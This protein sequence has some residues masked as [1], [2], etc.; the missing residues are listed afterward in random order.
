MLIYY[1]WIMAANLRSKTAEEKEDPDDG[2]ERL[3]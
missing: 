3:R 1:N 2:F